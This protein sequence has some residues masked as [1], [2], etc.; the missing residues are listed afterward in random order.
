MSRVAGPD[1]PLVMGIINATPDSFSDG[2]VVA[3]VLAGVALAERLIAEGADWLDVGGESTRPGATPV[4]V[5]EEI[6]R[7]IPLIAAIRSLTQIPISV[8]TRKPAVARAA[9]AAGA[10]VWN[11]VAALVAPGSLEAAGELGCGVVLVH[12][13]GEPCTM[14]NAPYYDDVVKEVVEFLAERALAALDAGVARDRIWPDPGIGF[15]K[16]TEHNVALVA[17]LHRLVAVGFPVLVGASR[18]G[19]IRAIDPTAKTPCERLGGS[20]AVALEAARG[21]CDDPRP[22]RTGDGSG[23]E[24]E[25]GDRICKP[26]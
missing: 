15:G 19:F 20:L 3:G 17:G 11:D 2:G 1:R 9:V 10:T 12:M 25:C 21:G 4:S 6:E 8:D 7:V 5:S 22:R 16:T 13:Q 14:Q 18:K 26:E 24:S 23:A